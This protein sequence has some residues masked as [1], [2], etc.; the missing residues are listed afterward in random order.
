MQQVRLPEITVMQQ[1][2]IWKNETSGQD[3][4]PI[5][6]RNESIDVN[7]DKEP[8][9]K[10]H[11]PHLELKKSC[12]NATDE[13]L[14]TEEQEMESDQKTIDL[15]D[16]SPCQFPSDLEY[17]NENRHPTIDEMIKIS[18]EINYPYDTIIKRFFELRMVIREKCKTNDPCRK[19]FQ[20]LNGKENVLLDKNNERLLD[21]EFSKLRKNE[22][23]TGQFHLIM[24]KVCL[25]SHIIRKKY[26]EWF[27]K[28]KIENKMDRKLHRKFSNTRLVQRKGLKS[29]NGNQYFASSHNGKLENQDEME[30]LTLRSA[31]KNV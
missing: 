15:L 13:T 9:E 7:F 4:D 24:D 23:L 31:N 26:G 5:F 6:W 12:S 1:F 2:E 21:L 19:V 16:N 11:F 8:F 25:P 22:F 10:L 17:F 14:Q 3:L 28:R 29:S 27:K 30:K 20:F 18:K